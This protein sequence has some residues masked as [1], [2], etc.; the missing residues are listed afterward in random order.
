M[1]SSQKFIM[2]WFFMRCNNA[3]KC[4]VACFAMFACIL[5]ATGQG[6]DTFWSSTWLFSPTNSYVSA[7]RSRDDEG[8]RQRERE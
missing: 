1:E 4:K 7:L 8:G 6:A 5:I 2:R 3:Q